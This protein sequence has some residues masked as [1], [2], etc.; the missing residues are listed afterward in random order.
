MSPAPTS[1]PGAPPIV[2]RAGDV[3]IGRF[4]AM[5]SPCE[6]LVDTDDRAEAGS[7]A[8]RAADEA[9]R[10]EAKFSRYREDSV[11]GRLNRA[12]GAAT[13]VDEETARLLDYAAACW[14]ESN[15]LFDVT[16]GALRRAWT[17]DGSGRIP[18]EAAVRAALR[19]VGWARVRWDGSSLMMPAGMEIDLG[20]IGKEYA[21]DGAAAL[22]MERTEAPLL[23]N[24]G[25]DLF[26]SGPRRRGAPWIVGVDDPAR[27]GASALYR[28]DLLGGG[29]ATTGDARRFVI[30]DGKRLGHILDPR[31]GWPVE[32]PPASVT[33]LARSCLEAG[34]LSTLAYL[35]G[36]GAEAF[37]RGQGVEFRVVPGA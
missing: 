13:A 8:E 28:V 22:L 32:D 34:T 37:L 36:R 31:T 17:F 18:A 24:F 35:H 19:D 23:V 15:G 6:V 3:F 33:V 30:R 25:G 26:A 1:R 14:E 20:G 27:T 11:V 9:R 29:L 21:V 16:T 10:V 5:A 2:E 4:T 12:Q 7:L